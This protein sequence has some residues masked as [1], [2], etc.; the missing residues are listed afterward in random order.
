MSTTLDP[1]VNLE[2]AVW[3]VVNKKVRNVKV[4]LQDMDEPE[5]EGTQVCFHRG[6]VV[7]IV[8]PVRVVE[9][10]G[11]PTRAYSQSDLP[12][13]IILPRK[14][15]DGLDTSP[16]TE[17]ELDVLAI[18]RAHPGKKCN[19]LAGLLRCRPGGLRHRLAR[20]V[21]KRRWLT[22]HP[23]RGYHLTAAGTQ[24]LAASGGQVRS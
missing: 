8:Q 12:L 5:D 7:A 1:L 22:S 9:T 10:G 21:K 18:V 17:S 19:Q 24:V 14:P 20:L 3:E 2:A 13:G 23:K 15:A 6:G 4:I 11:G 16:P